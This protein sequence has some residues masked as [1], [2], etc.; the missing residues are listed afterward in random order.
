MYKNY[1]FDLYGT[2]I[3]INTNESKKYLW[4]KLTS[5][6]G[7]Y[8]AIYT[9]KELKECYKTYCKEEEEKN[10]NKVDF[11]EINI[12]KV[13]ERLFVEK[14][15]IPSKDTII[16][17]SKTFRAIST[18]YIK[19]YDGVLEFLENLKMKGKKIYLLS[20]AQRVFTKSEMDM[21]KITS[22]FDG[23]VFSSDE[24]IAKP[25]KRFYELILKRYNLNKKESIMI[26]NDSITDI[27]GSFYIG[28]DSLYIH[29]NISP[30]IKEPLLSKFSVMEVDFN[31][32]SK[33]ILI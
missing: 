30:K 4:D 5:I 26:G 9:S 33:K 27:Q 17:I 15:V 7:S 12:E 23:I 32:V 2:L 6:Y 22:Y 21:L 1:I 10:N 14:S 24:G 3:D 18:S 13:F 28:L 25:D 11:V 19:L 20:N 29:S 31:E 16:C 8:G